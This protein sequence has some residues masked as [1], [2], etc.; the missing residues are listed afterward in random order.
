MVVL[1]ASHIRKIKLHRA[2]ACVGSIYRRHGRV[3]CRGI[4]KTKSGDVAEIFYRDGRIAKVKQR[5]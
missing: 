5:I 4:V 1:L 2:G 3:A